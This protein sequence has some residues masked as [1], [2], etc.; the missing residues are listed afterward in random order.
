MS[1]IVVWPG[2]VLILLGISN[3]SAQAYPSK[4]IR[5]IV[6][7]PPGGGVDAAGRIIAQALTEQLSQQV[8]VDNRSGATGRIG[9]EMAAKSPADGYTLLLGSVAPSAI[10][11][12]VSPTVPYDAIKDF[13]PISLVGT[14]DYTLVVHP[15][16]PVRS[17]RDLLALAKAQ[18]RQL[19]FASGGILGAAHLAGELMKQLAK[20]DIVHVSYK[21][22]GP[23]TVSV[24]SGETVMTFTQGPAVTEAVKAHR[25][26]ALATT[27]SKRRIS[28]VPTMGETLPGYSVTQWFGVLAPAGTPRDIL[29]RLHKEIGRVI[30]SPKVVLQLMKFDTSAVTST[31]EEFLAFIK[32]EMEKWGKVIKVAKISVE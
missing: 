7:Y 11:P 17:T 28:D 5:L 27:G 24:L 20:V 15:S 6:P 4:P 22:V 14:T 2:I 19:T 1:K 18:P 16:L 32:S 30:A 23:A 29:N 31:P 8:V 10:I 9:T 12:S 3:A 26:R 21:G 25:L 13:S